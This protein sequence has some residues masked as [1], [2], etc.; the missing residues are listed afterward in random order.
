MELF[1]ASL[2]FLV[3]CLIHS[4][5]ATFKVK[6][7]FQK[8]SFSDQIIRLVYNFISTLTFGFWYYFFIIKI[9]QNSV[10][11]FDEIWTIIFN[12]MRILGVL[13]FLLALRDFSGTEF[14][15]L[16]KQNKTAFTTEGMFKLCRHPLYFFSILILIFNPSPTANQLIFSIGCTAY[17]WIGSYFEEKRMIQEIGEKYLEYKRNTPRFIPFLK[18][19]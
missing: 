2:S 18:L 3:C 11:H 8:I 19:T 6:K 15:G 17:F 9:Q 13:G 10:F 5:T 16:R 12:T 4:I 1:V 7:F 14:L